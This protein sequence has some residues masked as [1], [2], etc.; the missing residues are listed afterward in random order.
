MILRDRPCRF[1]P[2]AVVLVLA[3]GCGAPTKTNTAELSGKVTYN[4]QPV[5]AGTVG[6]RDK[7]GRTYNLDILPD[8]TYSQTDLPPGEMKITVETESANTE[9]KGTGGGR[10]AEKYKSNMSGAGKE[11]GGGTY[12]KIPSRYNDVKKSP[13]S[14]TLNPGKNVKDLEL[15]D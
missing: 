3:F 10:F 8:G 13:L 5:T 12:V 6:L 7:D 11:G 9:H 14:V 4:G 2:I 15:T 1:L